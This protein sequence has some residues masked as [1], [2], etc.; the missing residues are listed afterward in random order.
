MTPVNNKISV[1]KM[2]GTFLYILI[3]PLLLLIL[4]GDWF[5]TEG[6]IFSIWFIVLCYST[7]I[8]LYR[9]DP[10]LLAERYKKPGTAN[11][12]GWDTYVVAGLVIGFFLWIVIM[13]LD[14]RRFGWTT[15]FPLWVK[16]T[17]GNGLIFS[18]F[19]FYRS[20]TDNTFLSPLVRIQTERK[21]KVV[22]TGVYGF[23]RHPMYLGGTLLFIGTPMLL[24]S[25]YGLILGFLLLL[26]LSGRI[27]GEEKMLINELEGY[28]AYKKRVKYRLLPFV[29]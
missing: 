11:Q 5:W 1:I 7:I 14:A 18:F 29:W 20:Y 27:I 15:C 23:V 12:K 24:G 28:A 25:S 9:K 22:S 4:S 19:F 8:Y 16:I 26:L 13:P 21:Q 10:A 17:G 3:F 6:L 2:T